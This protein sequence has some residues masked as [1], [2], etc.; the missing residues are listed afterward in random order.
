MGV[1]WIDDYVRECVVVVY[2]CD[3]R[4]NEPKGEKVY[5]R[6]KKSI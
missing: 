3:I 2:V 6:G 1:E 4:S 5:K